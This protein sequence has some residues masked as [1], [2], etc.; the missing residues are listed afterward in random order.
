[1][2]LVLHVM[3][4]PNTGYDMWFKNSCCLKHLEFLQEHIWITYYITIWSCLGLPCPVWWINSKWYQQHFSFLSYLNG[5]QGFKQNLVHKL[6]LFLRWWP[7]YLLQY[8]KRIHTLHIIMKV[9]QR[10]YKDSVNMLFIVW[11][12]TV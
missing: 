8:I 4:S 7:V 1:M 10:W 5:L 2:L 12:S 9:L 6:I 3:C 11:F